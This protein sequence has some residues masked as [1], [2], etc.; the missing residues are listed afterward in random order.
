MD[1]HGYQ[2]ISIDVP[3]DIHRYPWITIDIHGTTS[4]CHTP[5]PRPPLTICHPHHCALEPQLP[6][7]MIGWF[8]EHLQESPT[9]PEE[10]LIYVSSLFLQIRQCQK[11]KLRLATGTPPALAELEKAAG[12]R[13]PKEHGT[14]IPKSVENQHIFEQKTSNTSIVG[15]QNP[16]K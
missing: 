11:T 3:M 5:V 15:S 10:M 14:F 13:I 9:H 2:W 1:I 6:I 16:Q 12:G 8:R 7:S 4:G